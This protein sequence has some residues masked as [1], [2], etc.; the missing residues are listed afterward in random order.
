MPDGRPYLVSKLYTL[1]LHE[2]SNLRQDIETWLGAALTPH[3]LSGFDVESLIG[4]GCVVS[5]VQVQKPDG[6]IFANV[7]S[8]L[9]LPK[10][11]VAPAPADYVRKQDRLVSQP[12]PVNGS[13][14]TVSRS[15]AD[16][17]PTDSDPSDSD[18]ATLDREAYE[19][20][21]ERA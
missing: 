2:R 5:V 8:I 9:K 6:Q 3:Q 11:I 17:D 15:Q 16:S 1:S 13:G 10:G 12:R 14:G 20:D 18:L 4:R 21:C 19:Q 7:D